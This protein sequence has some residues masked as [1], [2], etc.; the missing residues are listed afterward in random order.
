MAETKERKLVDEEVLTSVVTAI[1]E[2]VY[3]RKEHDEDIK[4]AGLTPWQKEYLEGIEET[5]VKSKMAVAVSLSP[6][7]KET[8]GTETAIT[9]T[10]TVKYDNVLVDAEVAGKDGLV[11]TKKSTGTYTASVSYPVPTNDN[12]SNTKS[13]GCS[14]TYDLEGTKITKDASATFTLYSQCAILQTAG[15]ALPTEAQIKAATNK[16]RAITGTYDISVTP[17]QYV[18]LCVPKGLTQIKDIKSSGFGVPFETAQTV[19]VN[20]GT[21]TV[22]YQCY[23]IS[24][25]PQ[26]SPMSVVIS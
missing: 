12:G 20:V 7:S 6:A 2:N 4:T 17:G 3:T 1:R 13:Y 5:E 22:S 11:F 26:S 24:G 19:A 8:V 16:R 10:A 25:A 15:T 23:R 21:Q 9:V 14:A 18:W